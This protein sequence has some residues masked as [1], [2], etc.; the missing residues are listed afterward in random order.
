MKLTDVLIKP[1]LTEKVNKQTEKFRRYT[2]IVAR[3]ANS[4]KLKKR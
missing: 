4:L 3:K 2:F 1:I